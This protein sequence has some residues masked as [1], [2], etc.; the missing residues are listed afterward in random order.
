M[1]IDTHLH[2]D[3]PWLT[4]ES[5]RQRTI[6]DITESNIVTWAQSC[7]V[8]SYEKTLEYSRKSRYIFPAFGILPW[9]ANQ[10]MDR[11]DEVATTCQEALMLGEIGLDMKST[12]NESTRKEQDALFAVF[13]EAAEK[14]NK[15]M[16]C[17][18]RGGIERDGLEVLKSYDVRKAIF[19]HYSG[20]PEMIDEITDNGFYISYGSPRYRTLSKDMREYLEPRIPRVHDDLLIIEID[21]LGRGKLYRPPSEI[22]PA[23][24]KTIAKMRKTAPEEIEALNHRNVLKLIEDDPKLEDMA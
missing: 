6:E 10:Y 16:N 1:K 24:L 7:S 21:V 15:I 13:L 19:H 22:F 11:L 18:F 20:A 17:H 4:D 5:L 23:I 14:Y 3:E 9:Y 2:L 12:R 8:P